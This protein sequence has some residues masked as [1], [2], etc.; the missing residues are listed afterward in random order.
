[1]ASEFDEL[2]DLKIK[3]FLEDYIIVEQ[4]LDEIKKECEK[5]PAVIDG[6][7]KEQIDISIHEL[8]EQINLISEAINMLPSDLDSQIAAMT[9]VVFTSHENVEKD[10]KHLEERIAIANGMALKTVSEAMLNSTSVFEQNLIAAK[11]RV[12]DTAISELHNVTENYAKEHD[13]ISKKLSVE[14]ASTT[15]QMAWVIIGA[16]VVINLV[17]IGVMFFTR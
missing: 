9:S 12:F 7:I 11:N 4:K 3:S 5:L 15:R 2:K 1:M 14:N 10:I 6:R 16:T 13:A 17:S 8:K